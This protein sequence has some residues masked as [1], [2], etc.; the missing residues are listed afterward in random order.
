M[1][2]AVFLPGESVFL[3]RICRELLAS[4]ATDWNDPD[5]DSCSARIVCV[6]LY[7]GRPRLDRPPVSGPAAGFT[8]V[9]YD[10]PIADGVVHGD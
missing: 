10:E 5:R 2:S 4:T 6:D 9:E 8:S 1:M 7:F 3:Q